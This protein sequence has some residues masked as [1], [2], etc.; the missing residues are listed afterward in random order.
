MTRMPA[1]DP[2]FDHAAIVTAVTGPGRRLTSFNN[3]EISFR[4]FKLR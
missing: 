3:F 2:Q 1:S 4:G